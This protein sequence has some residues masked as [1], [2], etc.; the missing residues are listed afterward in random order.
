MT[1]P[2]LFLLMYDGAHHPRFLWILHLPLSERRDLYLFCCCCCLSAV[3]L[4]TGG[5]SV[6]LQSIPLRAQSGAVYVIQCLRINNL[7]VYTITSVYSAVG[8]LG[9]GCEEDLK[10]WIAEL[11]QQARICCQNASWQRRAILSKFASPGVPPIAAFLPFGSRAAT[12]GEVLF[13]QNLKVLCEVNR[14]ARNKNETRLHVL[15]P[16][17]G[18]GAREERSL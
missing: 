3:D 16:W 4:D 17:P 1:Q 8:V 7:A 11:P 15:G 2:V 9:C 6:A 5:K 10:N 13:L 18:K 14:K 12:V